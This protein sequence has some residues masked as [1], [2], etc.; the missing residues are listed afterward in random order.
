M[1]K[2]YVSITEL[3]YN[4]RSHTFEIS[5]KFIGHDLEDALENAGV[6]SLNLGAPNEN[7][8]ANE[9]LKQYIDKNFQLIVNDKNLTF[10]FIGK[11]VKDND[12]MYCYLE[13]NEIPVIKNVDIKNTLLI[14]MFD[15][16]SNIVNLKV[17]DE[18]LSFT[19]NHEETLASDI[20]KI[21]K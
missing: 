3:E 1:H 21:K 12:F 11:E 8:K 4:S 16:Q 6:P 19:F 20:L 5:I 15:E 14:E 10:K 7:E 17:G 13:T 9:Y 2:Y 18:N